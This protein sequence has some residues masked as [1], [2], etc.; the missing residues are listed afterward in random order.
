MLVVDYQFVDHLLQ[1]IS[2]VLFYLLL[3]ADDEIVELAKTFFHLM[4]L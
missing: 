4:R 2:S 3:R 1:N